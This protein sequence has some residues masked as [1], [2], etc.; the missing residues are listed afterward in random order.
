MAERKLGGTARREKRFTRI[1]EIPFASARKMMSTIEADHDHDDNPVV[2]T[3]GAPGVP[4]ARCT[5]VRVGSATVALDSA[6]RK[7][8]LANVATLA[9]TRASPPE[10]EP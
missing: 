9:D 6:M 8:I 10:H 3:E 7:R 1:G 4:L 2:I 5:Q